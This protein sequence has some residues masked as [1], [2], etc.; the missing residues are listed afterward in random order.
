MRDTQAEPTQEELRE[1]FRKLRENLRPELLAEVRDSGFREAMIT[2]YSELA[3]TAS[4]LLHLL[5]KTGFAETLGAE[6]ARAYEEIL[7]R[8]STSGERCKMLVE[9]SSAVDE[10]AM[11]AIAPD[12]STSIN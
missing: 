6:D 4:A 5:R 10:Q 8:F 11:L 9:E 2:S 3:S 1:T 12:Y 7:A